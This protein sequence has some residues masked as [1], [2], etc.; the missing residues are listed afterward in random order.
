MS[1]LHRDSGIAALARRALWAKILI[2]LFIG[3]FALALI[4]AVWIFSREVGTGFGL[5]YLLIAPM[6]SPIG[7]VPFVI[8]AVAAALWIH[9]A[10]RNLRDVGI[11]DMRVSPTWAWM[12]F[13]VPVANLFVPFTAMRE[14]WNRS[15]GEDF[16]QAEATVNEVT[17]WWTCYVAGW[18]VQ[19]WLI[20]T[21]SFNVLTNLEILTPPGLNSGLGILSISLLLGSA[22]MLFKIIGA[23]T[24]AQRQS[25]GI[26]QAF[27]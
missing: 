4:W 2:G 7:F 9:Q 23:I 27:L 25:T 19:I 14:L 6:A 1:V 24:V 17:I 10:H 12:S 15:H 18:L 16:Y 13:L 22:V 5:A 3:I 21:Y 20:F 8:T 26:E 11:S